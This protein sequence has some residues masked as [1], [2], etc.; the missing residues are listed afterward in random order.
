MS[1]EVLDIYNA[2]LSEEM[3][4]TAPHT[5]TAVFDPDGVA[6]TIYGIFDNNTKRANKD[7]AN[8]TQKIEGPRFI[9]SSLS[10]LSIDVYDDEELFITR[11]NKTFI[12]DYVE[13]DNKG[14][15]T[16]WLR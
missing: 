8:Q 11:E 15:Q 5:E 14:V 2:H 9:V 7:G 3:G 10:A 16:I 1:S 4:V 6:T 13:T 12:I